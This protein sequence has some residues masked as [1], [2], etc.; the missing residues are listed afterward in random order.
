MLG[1]LQPTSLLQPHLIFERS[2][3]KKNIF[4]PTLICLPTYERLPPQPPLTL[5]CRSPRREPS[6][7]SDANCCCSRS[8]TDISVRRSHQALFEATAAEVAQPPRIR[9]DG[10][11]AEVARPPCFPAPPRGRVGKRAVAG[12]NGEGAAVVPRGEG[13]AAGRRGERAAAG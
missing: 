11:V 3:A 12:R 4:N 5:T 7:T 10:A 13:A 9:I 1:Q 6:S 2:K 8:P